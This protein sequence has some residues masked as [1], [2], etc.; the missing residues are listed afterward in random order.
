MN[1]I[2]QLR[3]FLKDFELMWSGKVLLHH[4]NEAIVVFDG[5]SGIFDKECSCFAKV[6][7]NIGAEGLEL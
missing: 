6:T 1:L 7:A 3:S 2:M 5:T 4:I